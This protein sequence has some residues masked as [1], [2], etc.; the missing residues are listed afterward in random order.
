[1]VDVG[2]H[3]DMSPSGSTM[4]DLIRELYPICR[5]IT[6]EGVRTTLR[7]LQTRIPLVLHEVPS[8]TRVFDWSVPLEWNIADAYIKNRRGERIVDFQ[9]SNLHVMSYS[10]PVRATMGMDDLRPHLF[11]CP[12]H[13][14]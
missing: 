3:C 12:D 11:A 5:S 10:T 2:T 13:P 8:G 4:H 14:E 7:A 9:A 6:G 1:M